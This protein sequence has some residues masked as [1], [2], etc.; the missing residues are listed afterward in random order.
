MPDRM[1]DHSL[2]VKV[3]PTTEVRTRELDDAKCE[4]VTY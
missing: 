1:N 3:L 2:L 4:G